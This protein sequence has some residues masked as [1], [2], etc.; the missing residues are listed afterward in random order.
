MGWRVEE[1]CEVV[2]VWGYLGLL[3]GGFG[4]VLVLLA[5]GLCVLCVV[6]VLCV[7]VTTVNGNMLERNNVL[8]L[9]GRRKMP[10]QHIIVRE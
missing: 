2:W 3:C 10:F 1:G 7:L 4:R 5:E 9:L 6:C 8:E